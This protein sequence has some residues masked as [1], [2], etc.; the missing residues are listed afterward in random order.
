MSRPTTRGGLSPRSDIS[1]SDVKYPADRPK[2]VD[3]M[4]ELSPESRRRRFFTAKESLNPA[5]LTYMTELDY[6]DHFA[7]V[8]LADGA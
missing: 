8:A 6:V 3:A 4:A 1:D 5:S 2:L 7:W